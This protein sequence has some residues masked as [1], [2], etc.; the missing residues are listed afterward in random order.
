MSSDLFKDNKKYISA[1][2][3]SSLT[4][5]S[6][7]YIGQLARGNKI[8][9]KKIR[10]VWYV[11]EKS[12]LQY[13]DF[14]IELGTP[15]VHEPVL[16]KNALVSENLDKKILESK[17]TSVI[18]P[19]PFVPTLI[20]LPP[21]TLWP[22][23]KKTS[24]KKNIS[25]SQKLLLTTFGF[26]VSVGVF[27]LIDISSS[28]KQ[29]DGPNLTANVLN[30]NPS[31]FGKLS[32]NVIDAF[33]DLLFHYFYGPEVDYTNVAVIKHSTKPIPTP[34]VAT[35]ITPELITKTKIEYPKTII[36]RGPAGPKGSTGSRG[37]TGLQGLKGDAGIQ[38]FNSTSSSQPA[39]IPVYSAP[40]GIIQSNPATNYSGGSLFSA[41]DLSSR[42]FNTTN[43]N[44]GSL[45]VSGDSILQGNLTTMAG[46]SSSGTINFSGLT[47][48]RGV[49]TDGSKNLTSTGILGAD[50]GGTGI[51]NNVAS[52]F[53]ISGNFGTT[54]TISG[55]TAVTLPT[56]GTLYG[57]ATGSITSLQLATSLSDETGSGLA[58]FG[59]SPTISGLTLSGFTPGSML[60]TGTS[61]VVIQ[62]NAN[63][64]FDDTN[65][66]LGIGTTTPLA[67]FD[68]RQGVNGETM[69][70]G[71]RFTDVAP[72][73][74][75]ITYN[76][77]ANDTALFRVDNSGNLF[78][79][80]ILNSGSQTITSTSTPQ[81]RVQYNALNE[82][83]LSVSSAGVATYGFNGTTPRA[84]WTPQSN[85]TNTFTFTDSSSN[86]I[87]NIDTTNQRVGIGTA[88]S[89][90]FKL[91]VAGNIGPEAD[92][93]RDLG[94]VAKRWANLYAT[95]I[96]GAIT[97]TGFTQGSVA[98]AGASGMLSQ[99][100]ANFFID[101]TN[102]TLGI[103][104]TRTGVISA[105]NARLLLKGSGVTSATSSFDV[106]DSTGASNFFVRDDGNVGIGTTAPAQKLDV[107][108]NI[109]F[110]TNGGQAILVSNYKGANSDGNNLFI[111][112]GGQSSIGEVGA[113]YKGSSNTANG[114][115]SLLSNTT[116]Y[117][118]TANG[119]YS[120]YSNTTG[121]SNTANGYGSLYSNTTGNQN[122]ANGFLSLASNTTGSSNTA[123]G[124][125]SLYNNTTGYQ[126][127]ANGYGSLTFNTTGLS[128]TA[129]GYYSLLSNTTGNNNT[130]NG[131]YSLYSNTT[132]VNN[133]ANG[134]GSLY[135]F[136]VSD[137]SGNNTAI[138]YNTGRGIVTGINN[139]ILGANV[140]GLSSTLSN[141]IIIADGSGNQRIN[142]DSSGNVGIGVTNPL[143]KLTVGNSWT[144]TSPTVM[145][146]E[147]SS[148][149]GYLPSMSI[150]ASTTN[151]T[152]YVKSIGLNL[153]NNDLTLG[154]RTPAIS[155]SQRVNANYSASIGAIDVMSGGGKNSDWI[156]GSMIFSTAG[157]QDYGLKE[158]MR[159]TSLGYVGIGKTDPNNKLM[160]G[161]NTTNGLV[162]LNGNGG[163]DQTFPTVNFTTSSSNTTNYVYSVGLNL[164][165]DDITAGGRSAALT[166][167]KKTTQF[168]DTLG[169]IDAVDVGVGVNEDWHGG[170]MVF[171]TANKETFGIT[172]KM[173]ITSTGNVGIGV[174][175]P[176]E[177]LTVV[178]GDIS[179]DG[180][181]A[182]ML[183]HGSLNNS[184]FRNNG[185]GNTTISSPSNSGGISFILN[186]DPN[187]EI[188]RAYSGA[189]QS[190]VGIGITNP[191][192]K[193]HIVQNPINNGI[194]PGIIYV[195]AVHN[196]QTLSTEISSVN[197]TTAGRQWAT[198][199]I[200]ME[201]EVLITQPT[202]SFVGASTITDAA[203]MS[204]VGAPI[205]GTNATLTN[206][207]GLL[208]QAGA[209]STAINSYGLT[210]NAQT[211]A[212][213]NYVATFLGGNVGIGTT[214]PG[215]KL[216][217]NTATGVNFQDAIKLVK[218]G[219]YGETSI[220]NYYSTINNFGMGFHTDA[221]T[222]MVINNSGNV[223]IGTINPGTK[224]VVT[225]TGAAIGGGFIASAPLFVNDSTLSTRGVAIGY[226]ATLEAG[227]I[228]AGK[229]GVAYEPLLLNP[230]AGNVG[231]GTTFPVSKFHVSGGGATGSVDSSTLLMIDGTGDGI[232][233]Q[234]N[235][236]NAANAETLLAF[237]YRNAGNASGAVPAAI[238]Y[239]IDSDGF[240]GQTKGALVFKTRGGTT[241]VA[242]TERM[243]I[244]SSGNVGI[245]TTTPAMKLSVVQGASGDLYP[246]NTQAIFEYNANGGIV[247]AVPDANAGGLYFPKSTDA[248]YSGIERSTSNLNLRNNGSTRLTI[249]SSG[250]VGIG[251]TVPGAKLDA[252]SSTG[253][254]GRFSGYTYTRVAADATSGTIQI[255][256]NTN[257]SGYIDYG[258][259]SAPSGSVNLTFSNSYDSPADGFLFRG[260][261]SGT[262]VNAM[263]IQGNGNVGIGL[264]N[265]SDKLVVYGIN[266]VIRLTDSSQGNTSFLQQLDN[267]NG[268]AL[269]IYDG[270]LYSTY[271]K[272]GNV[273]I[274]TTNPGA[275]L[276]VNGFTK[277]TSGSVDSNWNEQLL[278]LGNGTYDPKIVLGSN[279]GYRWSIRNADPSSSGQLS[280]RY[281]EG[282]LDA[283]TISRN[284]NVGIGTT[285][286]SQ[287][288]EVMGD[289]QING[290]LHLD[291]GAGATSPL[292][293]IILAGKYEGALYSNGGIRANGFQ[294]NSPYDGG[295]SLQRNYY[296]GA[297]YVYQDVLNVT[298][299]GNVGIGTTAPG[300]PLEV[301]GTSTGGTIAKFT[302]LNTTGC[303]LATGGTISCSS[304]QRLKK[305]VTDISYGLD[306]VMSLHPVLF[307]WNYENDG[308]TKNLGFIAQEVEIVV[309]KLVSTD[310]GGMKSLNTTA[311]VPILTKSIQELNLNMKS[312]SEPIPTIGSFGDKFF[313]N[314]FARLIAWF[315]NSA[316]GIGEFFA[317]KA[318]LEEVCLKDATGTSCYNRTQLDTLLASAVTSA[319]GAQ[320]ETLRTKPEVSPVVDTIAPVITLTGETNITLNVG[321][322]YTEA[323]ATATDNVD[324]NVAVVISG[325]VDTTVAGTYI[326]NYNAQDT[327][328]NKAIEVIRT[329]N[330]TVLGGTP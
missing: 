299:A 81:F 96:T 311:I 204:I 228:Q 36:I 85:L 86:P 176:S 234:L 195:G 149:A 93:T 197:I 27:S 10:G 313:T 190:G 87:L 24:L 111:G 133:T 9:S 22:E 88:T 241:G 132:G 39:Y 240:T 28:L 108:G 260:R 230:N 43:A 284:G 163:L 216:Q 30:E 37:L 310:D 270:T 73:G 120:L 298:G 146:D 47:A 159:I 157:S 116:G 123:N 18:L 7:D 134:Y 161:L 248:Y 303:T 1:K 12:I 308:T 170:D 326:V 60:F 187:I 172:E 281:E 169:A 100:N 301:K 286:P 55:S 251:T 263:M 114:Y 140:T 277:I 35:V 306:T 171:H 196:S 179:V 17:F 128:N 215:A 127:T 136:N 104:S 152:L 192:A 205:N 11:E 8:D 232:V 233:A 174:T 21:K 330:V 245:G 285:A 14:S 293:G 226:D 198:G 239:K 327:A 266:P 106:Q 261:T 19:K 98:F 72:S 59:T 208:I 150:N 103:G 279:N 105:T 257:Y 274:G 213:N 302:D 214:G 74:D 221:G 80:G 25:L 254:A 282:S 56:S 13:N 168:S 296:N 329:I 253:S 143:H 84:I 57:T 291:A 222:V 244:D 15:I 115:G 227:F 40:I 217:I 83:S 167:G 2:E 256:S 61:G 151:S 69:F 268:A 138:G 314:L 44:I 237:S 180:G 290:G 49:F 238:G 236:A 147:F 178:G 328:G 90:T 278:V 117:Q 46:I 131:V 258:G 45:N 64:F 212:T 300:A 75:F 54:F 78:A 20:H 243:R 255:G 265:P 220:Q 199:N 65:N 3:A 97:P 223:G 231:I 184:I 94:A 297:A 142:V 309:P 129:N 144:G 269:R 110:N 26:L 153:H 5:Y 319:Q 137:G 71:R 317:K 6:R 124:F 175:N 224:L 242:P 247:V 101:D 283:M 271:F 29:L 52:T 166:F 272:G 79:G 249:D 63:L 50:Q 315:A 191:S 275:K 246:T 112:G 107:V 42:N 16:K 262:A 189:F 229:Q 126:N 276:E 211:G 102:N 91:E 181:K 89:N 70:S 76:N 289:V 109:Q 188:M 154:V 135:D 164:L 77:A 288:L 185:T 307:N 53:T 202:Y 48:S 252:V 183:V 122:T 225:G 99:D 177:K 95:N 158:R 318:T 321:D 182:I 34:E 119:V 160:V 51:A 203:T 312:I 207:Y 264:T 139:T 162:L 201:R 66:R 82:S 141:N 273:G 193:L 323:G 32:G 38:T 294:Q 145:T 292:S 23:I 287:K 304:D 210:V 165:N 130:A 33:S 200:S 250:N 31:Y 219:G 156:S 209:V 305:N 325:T 155:F 320:G 68:L 316:N 259:S 324:T 295:V 58:V 322:T 121:L 125:Y 118:N 280:F 218:D 235:N 92:N 148:L 194:N 41:T 62:D 67:V 173:R 206:T 113:T 186:G 4:G 267:A